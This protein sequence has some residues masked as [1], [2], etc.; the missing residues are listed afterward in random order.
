MG[1]S[2]SG[3]PRGPL[4]DFQ[5]PAGKSRRRWKCDALRYLYPTSLRKHSRGHD[6][7]YRKEN[8]SGIS[9]RRLR[10]LLGY[11]DELSLLTKARIFEIGSAS[12]FRNMNRIP[13]RTRREAYFLFCFPFFTSFFITHRHESPVCAL[14]KRWTSQSLALSTAVNVPRFYYKDFITNFKE[15]LPHRHQ[16]SPSA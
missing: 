1:T 11:P 2:T 8:S 3:S 12:W 15:A 7:S 16:V 14:L 6:S 13:F 5:G 9:G 10:V 4:P